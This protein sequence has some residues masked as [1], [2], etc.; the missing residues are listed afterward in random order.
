[1]TPGDLGKEAGMFTGI[2]WIPVKENETVIDC[3]PYT[4]R[5]LCVCPITVKG[6]SPEVTETQVLHILRLRVNTKKVMIEN[7]CIY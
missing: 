5:I 7:F 4:T 2:K 1:M 6:E 3:H